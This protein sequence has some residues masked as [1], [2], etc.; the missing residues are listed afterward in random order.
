MAF[1]KVAKAQLYLRKVASACR[2]I[3]YNRALQSM[4]KEA[5]GTKGWMNL[6]ASVA[7]NG[8]QTLS[9]GVKGLSKTVSNF[10]TN[11]ANNIANAASQVGEKTQDFLGGVNHS[12]SGQTTPYYNNAALRQPVRPQGTIP[13]TPAP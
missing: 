1:L 4:Q 6:G 10:S 11:T 2:V 13:Q 12:L 9:N 5:G 3:K 8:L 7:N